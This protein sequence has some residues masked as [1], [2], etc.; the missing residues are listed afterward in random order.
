MSECQFLIKGV[1]KLDDLLEQLS[2]QYV[3]EHIFTNVKK[4]HL[5]EVLIPRLEAEVNFQINQNIKE[6]ER[7]LAKRKY[8][9]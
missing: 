3:L 4:K 7:I 1:K 5:K 8:E 9:K 2:C 6:A